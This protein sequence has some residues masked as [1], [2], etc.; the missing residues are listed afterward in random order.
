MEILKASESD[1]PRIKAFFER[2]VLPGAIDFTFHRHGSFFD[3]Y[4]LFSDDHET[5]LMVDD[6]FEIAGMA[7]VLFR[8]GIVDGEKQSWAFATDLR[9]APTRKA[10]SQ[11]AQ[12]FLPVLEESC[13]ARRCRYVFSAVQSSDNQAYNALIRPT[14][15][16]RRRLP[17]YHLL[18][19]FRVVGLHGRVPFNEKPLQSIRLSELRHADLEPLCAFLLERGRRRILANVATPTAFIEELGRWP[20]LKLSDF[21]IAKDVRGRIL[22]CA[23]LWDGRTTQTYLP[24]TYNGFANTLKQTLWF[25]SLLK[26]VR[27]LAEPGE[28]MAMRY[29]THLHCDSPE[30][31]HRLAD[32]AFSRL[33][34][35]EFLAYMHFRGNWRTLPPPSFVSTS[36]PYGFYLVLPPNLEVPDLRLRLAGT[37]PMEVLPPEF[38]L[39]WL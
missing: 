15:H 16:S 35:P 31:F 4:R 17:R 27:P 5:L 26:M 10:I 7:S 38:E 19:K 12:K 39:A 8:E 1:S 24:Q 32:E 25:G 18:N 29:L 3:Q 21:R 22:G 30:V 37:G 20:G 23:A 9:I 6:D 11:W 14:S 28:P 13:N 36:L 33:K 2:M 34:R